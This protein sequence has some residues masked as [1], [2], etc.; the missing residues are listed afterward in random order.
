M[1]NKFAHHSTLPCVYPPRPITIILLPSLSLGT[2]R[3]CTRW[4]RSSRRGPRNMWYSRY[5][6]E[7][8][9]R[10]AP[11]RP[12]SQQHA[13]R[14]EQPTIFASD[15]IKVGQFYT[16]CKQR[17]IEQFL[18]KIS[19]HLLYY[20]VKSL[21]HSSENNTDN[22]QPL[23]LCLETSLANTILV[24]LWFGDTIKKVRGWLSS[25]WFS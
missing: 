11:A 24:M 22:R 10:T 20:L 13:T 3:S 18:S 17:A 9:H 2:C 1:A 15:L 14:A 5:G 25:V 21:V 16:L 4:G 12:L 6:K 23:D 7:E 8:A 19:H